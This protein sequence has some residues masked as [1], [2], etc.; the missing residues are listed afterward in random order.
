MTD[1]EKEGK[2]EELVRTGRR[3]ETET[4]T[5]RRRQEEDKQ[6]EQIKIEKRKGERR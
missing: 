3:K 2:S 6:R 1:E 4:G 5:K